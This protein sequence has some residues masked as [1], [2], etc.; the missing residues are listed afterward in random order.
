MPAIGLIQSSCYAITFLKVYPPVLI[1]S[2]FN[3]VVVGFQR[4]VPSI[5][6]VGDRPFGPSSLSEYFGCCYVRQ[7]FVVTITMM[8]AIVFDSV[9]VGIT[10]IKLF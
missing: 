1:V 3:F 10:T 8:I 6:I 7:L 2:R 5:G 4:M 9:V